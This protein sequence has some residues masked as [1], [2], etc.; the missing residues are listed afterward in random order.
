MEIQLASSS[1]ESHASALCG[2]SLNIFDESLIFSTIDLQRNW[3]ILAVAAFL[4]VMCFIHV[5]VLSMA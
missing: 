1:E 4:S 5:G 2:T 3:P